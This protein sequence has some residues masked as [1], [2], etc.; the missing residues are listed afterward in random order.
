MTRQSTIRRKALLAASSVVL[1]LSAGCRFGEP[2]LPFGGAFANGIQTINTADTGG[3][4]IDPDVAP[5]CSASQGVGPCCES[6]AAWCEAEHGVGN[7]ADECLFGPD[8]SGSTG[9]IPWGPP[10]PP[11]LRRMV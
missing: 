10:A 5:D 6:L 9:C 11:R 2:H 4:P 8:F 7:A 3:D 1:A